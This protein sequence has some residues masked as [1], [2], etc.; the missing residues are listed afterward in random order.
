M[1]AVAAIVATLTLIS[2]C[3]TAPPA[4]DTADTISFDPRAP[5][6]YRAFAPELAEAV[7]RAP[8]ID[9]ETG[10]HVSEVKPGLFWVTDGIYRRRGMRAMSPSSTR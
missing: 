8:Q 2:A 6:S 3:V 5:N 10:V 7:A 9:P 4:R 1:K